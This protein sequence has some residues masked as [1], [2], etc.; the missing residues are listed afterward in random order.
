[1]LMKEGKKDEAETAKNRMGAGL[2]DMTKNSEGIWTYTTKPLDSELY[3]YE[4]MVD[5]VP[6]IDPN[7]VYVYRDF[8]TSNFVSYF[9]YC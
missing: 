7:N 9:S 3:S 5:G 6:T 1:M 8:A 4:F 2:I